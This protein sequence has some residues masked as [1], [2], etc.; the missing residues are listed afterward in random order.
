MEEYQRPGSAAWSR[1]GQL[2]SEQLAGL[3]SSIGDTPVRRLEFTVDGGREAELVLKLEG[4]NPGGSIKDRTALRL[5]TGLREQGCLK[6]GDTVV[7]STSG[8]LGVALAYLARAFG[9][10]FHAVVD[11]HIT[12]ENLAVL[13]SLGARVDIVERPDEHGSFLPARLAR[14]RELCAARPHYVW[15]NQYGSGLNP[16]AH[17]ATTAP[18]IDTQCGERL[19]AVIAAVSTGGT[20]AGL[21]RYFREHRPDVVVV[22]VDVIG[23]SALGGPLGPRRLNGIGSSRP[24]EFL[25][26]GTYDELV[27]V[28]D[29][30]AV[31]SCHELWNRTGIKVGAS[32][33]AAI[34]GA[35]HLLARR[36]LT[37][38]ACICPDDGTKYDTSIYQPAWLAK[39]GL[40]ISQSSA[41][42]S[43]IRTTEPSGSRSDSAPRTLAR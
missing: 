35:A 1:L 43:T 42:F 11:P 26:A 40:D 41:P 9:Y 23:S 38:I 6:P 25:A 4:F 18:E 20:L 33:G 7:E 10:R 13:T 37:Q 22:A 21:A 14:V 15:T 27:Y 28:S 2:S 32:S 24:S 36:E 16:L 30:E 34:A 19:Q 5:F 31:T 3:V 17:Y 29:L 8:N 39:A 12:A